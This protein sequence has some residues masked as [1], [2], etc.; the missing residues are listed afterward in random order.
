MT[1]N[2]DQLE[3]ALEKAMEKVISKKQNDENILGID[4]DTHTLDHRYVGELRIRRL[5]SERRWE[6]FR[7]SI[8]GAVGAAFVGGL[9]W[10]GRLII[11]AFRH[12]PK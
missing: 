5:K 11:E 10:I 6:K 4:K 7:L 1:F 8:I 2:E 9:V 3:H 12:S